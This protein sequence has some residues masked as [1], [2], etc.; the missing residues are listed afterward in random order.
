MGQILL[1]WLLYVVVFHLFGGLGA[2]G[3]GLLYELVTQREFSDVLY[4][5][6]FGANG[7][8]AYR[9]AAAWLAGRAR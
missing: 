6:V 1:H 8:I 5:V 7:F 4:A 9:L 2:G 3:A